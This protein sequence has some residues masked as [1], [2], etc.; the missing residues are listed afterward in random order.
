MNDSSQAAPGS[1]ETR[2]RTAHRR[3]TIIVGAITGSL[4]VYAALVEV[5]SRTNAVEA[6]PA[7]PEAVRWAFY[8]IA[9]SMVFASHVVKAFMLRG[10]RAGGVDE[11]LARLTTAN[12]VTAAIAET[13]AILGFVLFFISRRY[14][15]D[16]YILAL[17]SLYL[18]VRHFPRYGQWERMIR[19]SAT[20]AG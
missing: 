20:E 11:L 6:G 14:Y 13:P 1:I 9:V 2:A 18:L 8:A 16:F 19:E 4:F 7:S 3:A 15:S 17:I 12:V 10:A 5:L